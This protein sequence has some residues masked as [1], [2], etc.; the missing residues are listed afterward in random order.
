MKSAIGKV[1]GELNDS[2][3][4]AVNN[5]D[6]WDLLHPINPD[7]TNSIA[8]EIIV[9]LFIRYYITNKLYLS[10]LTNILQSITK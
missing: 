9:D 10:K 7:I 5:S 6:F 4:E 3:T 1:V 8:A 2:R